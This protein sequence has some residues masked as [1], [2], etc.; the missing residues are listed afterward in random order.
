MIRTFTGK[1]QSKG[2]ALITVMLIIALIAILATQMTARL[3]LQMQRTTNIGSNQQAYWYAMGAEAFA[4]RVLIQSFEADSE[5][6][7]LSQLWA[8][9]ENTFPVDFGEIT[10]EITDLNSCFNLNALRVNDD[11]GSG[12]SNNVNSANAAKKSPA[13]AAFEELLIAMNI[14]GVG[15]F[16]AE[17]MADALTDWLDTDGSISGSGGA[18]DND[19]ASKEF[20][21]LAANNYL[22]S[23]G[24]LRV[25]DHFTVNVIDKLKDY[26]CILPNTNMN[27]ININTIAQD[28]P[29]IL[30]AM[31]GISQ[32]EASQALSSRGD[33]GF[34]NVDEFFSLSEL[35]KAKI[36]P[37]KKQLFAVKSEYF[38]LKTTASFNNSYFALNTIMK[39]DNKN[40]ISVISRIIGRE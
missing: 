1:Y 19:Y 28:Q 34:K 14:E 40:N 24:E 30:V 12:N 29:E 2:V 15:S 17:Y 20:P 13:R 6:T 18:E 22:A 39:V 11:D 23:M 37:E 35:S 38:K 27:K 4:K 8:Q 3:Q 32:N 7:H 36:P 10:G 21:Y 31:L 26:A 33:E 9:G 5:V 25:I 16:E